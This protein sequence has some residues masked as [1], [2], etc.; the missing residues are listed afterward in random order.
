MKRRAFIA[1]FGG[2]AAAWPL[3]A[4]AQQT[5]MP[6]IGLPNGRSIDDAAYLVAAFRQGLNEAGYVEGQNVAIEYLWADIDAHQSSLPP[7][8]TRRYTES[9]RKPRACQGFQGVDHKE[10]TQG[11]RCPRRSDTI[12]EHKSRKA[13]IA[14]GVG[15]P[16][17]SPQTLY[18]LDNR[19]YTGAP[20][21]ATK[22]RSPCPRGTVRAEHCVYI[23][24]D[25]RTFLQWM[26]RWGG[27]QHES[28]SA[29]FGI[30]YEYLVES[31]RAFATNQRTN[32]GDMPKFMQM[33]SEN[34][35]EAIARYLSA[36]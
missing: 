14:T 7:V 18:R 13:R 17:I 36:L 21:R 10:G 16:D 34:Q 24:L 1:L 31:M 35:R 29:S 26:S 19:N 4:R 23:P 15:A 32:N 12:P 5:A 6:V 3:A 30:S 20:K 8:R 28:G 11:S 33:L 9:K 22:R 25:H 27:A 2:A